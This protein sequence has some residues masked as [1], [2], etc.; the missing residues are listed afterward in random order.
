MW[1][2]YGVSTARPTSLP[3]CKACSASLAFAS[4]IGVT[5]IGLTV[6]AV[7]KD[8]LERVAIP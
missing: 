1:C 7:I 6:D 5:G 8:I 3:S 4:G 2:S